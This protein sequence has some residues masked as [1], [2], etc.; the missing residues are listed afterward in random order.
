M[1]QH[2]L[3]HLFSYRWNSHVPPLFG[4][5]L[6]T[7]LQ[8]THFGDPI[9]ELA[10]DLLCEAESKLRLLFDKT[11]FFHPEHYWRSYILAGSFS[12]F[13]IRR[14]G[15]ETYKCLYYQLRADGRD[16]L[17]FTECFGLPLEDAEGQ[18]RQDILGNAEC[19][20]PSMDG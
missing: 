16:D 19:Q 18:W 3:A 15:W 1:L 11:F 14:F 17:R 12:G 6:S 4:E 7:W 5:G 9:D 10:R 2:E 20:Q 13:L 8:D